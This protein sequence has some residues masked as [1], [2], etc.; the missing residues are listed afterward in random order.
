MSAFI[1][2]SLLAVA[3]FSPLAQAEEALVTDCSGELAPALENPILSS[4]FRFESMVLQAGLRAQI[5]GDYVSERKLNRI[6]DQIEK[7]IT[8]Y[9]ATADFDPRDRVIELQF[10]L[11]KIE[12]QLAQQEGSFEKWEGLSELTGYLGR[13]DQLIPDF[14][15]HIDTQS[16]HDSKVFFESAVVHEFS[17]NPQFGT[18]VLIL[19]MKGIVS[20]TSKTGVKLLTEADAQGWRL[21]EVK[22]MHHPYGDLRALLIHRPGETRVFRIL[23]N[24]HRT[25]HGLSTLLHEYL[26]QLKRH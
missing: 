22:F 6:I 5:V 7:L 23:H 2:A 14:G 18:R 20:P 17:R 4:V 26:V 13:A 1:L 25:Q 15:Y 9:G 11:V 24:H 12:H 8:R 16:F 19:L 10:E 3:S 21:M